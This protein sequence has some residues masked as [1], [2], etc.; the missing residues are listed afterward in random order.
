MLQQ[1]WGRP[2]DQ[3]ALNIMAAIR[4]SC[5]RVASYNQ[6]TTCDAVNWRVTVYLEE[7]NRTIRKIDQEVTVALVGAKHGHG[8]HKYLVGGSPKA[9]H[10][11]FNTRGLKKLQ[12]KDPE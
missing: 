8:L 7:D 12:I 6:P 2:W 1:L 4:P 5:I 3:Y 10:A 9:C 11:F